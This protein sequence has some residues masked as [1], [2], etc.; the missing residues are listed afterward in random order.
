MVEFA[1]RLVTSQAG[2]QPG[3]DERIT[4][5]YNY[6]ATAAERILEDLAAQKYKLSATIEQQRQMREVSNNVKLGKGYWDKVIAGDPTQRASA[7]RYYNKY[8]E[9]QAKW[10]DGKAWE[11]FEAKVKVAVSA[12]E[13]EYEVGERERARQEKERQERERARISRLV[14]GSTDQRDI[15]FALQVDQEIGGV[16]G[17]DRVICQL[18][19]PNGGQ[20]R[21]ST[22][23]AVG[24]S[25]DSGIPLWIMRNTEKLMSKPKGGLRSVASC[26]E[27]KCLLQ[28]MKAAGI[29]DR[30]IN[31][32][33][34]QDQVKALLGAG[35]YTIARE[36]T[37]RTHS[38]KIAC[39]NCQQWLALIGWKW[40]DGYG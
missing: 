16:A 38:P 35:G 18:N 2:P 33:S 26:T 28:Y 21:A 4:I 8:Q 27:F 6:Y 25:L 22:T 17:G 15:A 23:D 31:E 20:Y 24:A 5:W 19:A 11:V 39:L 30:G 36:V 3:A 12:I 1:R 40:A 9:D 34:S 10:E 37:G 7:L 32:D 13:R 14:K 29:D